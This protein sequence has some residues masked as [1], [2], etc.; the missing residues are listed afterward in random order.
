MEQRA[1]RAETPVRAAT[2]VPELLY[3]RA[4]GA[5]PGGPR[6]GAYRE[7]K[8]RAKQRNLLTKYGIYD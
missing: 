2:R 3:D 5:S 8:G 4:D 7:G 1:S 6:A